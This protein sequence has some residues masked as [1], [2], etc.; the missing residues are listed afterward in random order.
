MKKENKCRDTASAEL[1]GKHLYF[2]Y[3]SELVITGGL[4]LG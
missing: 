3:S 2:L 4:I 1:R